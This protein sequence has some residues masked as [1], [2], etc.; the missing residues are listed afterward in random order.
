MPG[1][2]APD[3]S[4]IELGQIFFHRRGQESNVRNFA[5]M[6][7]DEPDRLIGSHP[8]QAVEAGEVH[9]PGVTAQSALESEIEI[10]VEV[11][12]RQLSQRAVNRLAVSAAGK[13]GFGDR[14]PMSAHLKDR[15]YVVG[16]LIRFQIK[17]KRLESE[18][19]ERGR[20]KNSA[21]QT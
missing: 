19:P 12:H 13:V 5:K 6:L 1:H 3:A 8:V 11:T 14:A 16:V 7:G 2:L 9:W 17:N 20:R 21:F 10:D 4:R 15:D 18:D